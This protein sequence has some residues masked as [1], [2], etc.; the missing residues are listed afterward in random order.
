MVVS[1]EEGAV[2][3]PLSRTGGKIRKQLHAMATV[4]VSK[5]WVRVDRAVRLTMKPFFSLPHTPSKKILFC[6]Q[7]VLSFS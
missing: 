7:A 6:C 4:V 3:V 1:W 5:K 2:Y